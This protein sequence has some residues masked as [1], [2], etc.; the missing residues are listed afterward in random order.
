MNYFMYLGV[1]ALV[2]SCNPNKDQ[3]DA[4]G[5]FEATQITISA[6]T[7]G[8]IKALDLTEGMQVQQEQ[9]VGWIDTTQLH[10]KKEQVKAS[11]QAIEAR[12]PG[13]SSKIDILEEQ[14]KNAKREKERFENLARE[15]ATT[16]KQL[17]DINDH[18][19]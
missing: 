3:A 16:Q 11:I 17:D 4:Y 15:G 18:L 19:E 8:Q 1:A 10:L 6:E 14:L 12:K 7:S 5:N 9:L 2:I 13:I